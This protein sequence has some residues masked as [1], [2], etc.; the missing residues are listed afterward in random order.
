ME[1]DFENEE[2][3]QCSFRVPDRI[4]NKYVA[5]QKKEGFPTL[6][7]WIIKVLNKAVMETKSTIR[8]RGSDEIRKDTKVDP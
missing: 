7:S 5:Q 1:M 4:R 8:R 3:R 6:G 2:S